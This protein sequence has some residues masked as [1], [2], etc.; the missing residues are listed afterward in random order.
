MTDQKNKVGVPRVEAVGV[1]DKRWRRAVITI[2]VG[3]DGEDRLAGEWANRLSEC[4]YSK[5]RHSVSLETHPP[6]RSKHDHDSF[7]LGPVRRQ[8][9]K[10]ECPRNV[11]VRQVRQLRLLG[12]AMALGAAGRF[13]WRT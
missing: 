10:V 5:A 12:W 11:M 8:P 3:A 9:V 1:S 7:F 2:E 13:P 6:H 4:P